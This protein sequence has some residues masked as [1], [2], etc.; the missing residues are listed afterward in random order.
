MLI[1]KMVKIALGDDTNGDNENCDHALGDNLFSMGKTMP[2]P[3]KA[4]MAVPKKSGNLS[5]INY[6]QAE[7]QI[8][9]KNISD[10][11]CNGFATIIVYS[12]EE[13]R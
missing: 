9:N 1:M 7:N 2:M 5:V 6:I 10:N 12:I 8:Q 13:R 3:S 11:N 4:K